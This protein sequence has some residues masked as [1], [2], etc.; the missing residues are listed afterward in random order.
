MKFS[1]TR[2]DKI[3]KYA[4]AYYDA[5]RQDFVENPNFELCV[6]DNKQQWKCNTC[7]VK[8]QCGQGEHIWQENPNVLEDLIDDILNLF[9]KKY[10]I[11][12]IKKK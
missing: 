7:G 11:K 1:K 5:H 8:E 10:S 3:K 6:K 12:R 9:E 4:R 2:R